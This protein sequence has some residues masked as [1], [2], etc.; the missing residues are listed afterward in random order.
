M[1]T[2]EIIEFAPFR[3]K[4]RERGNIGS[5][6]IIVRLPEEYLAKVTVPFTGEN[7]Y[8]A[9]KKTYEGTI[10]DYLELFN[11]ETDDDGKFLDWLG[12]RLDLGSKNKVCSTGLA[13]ILWDTF[14]IW[15]FGEYESPIHIPPAAYKV[16]LKV[17]N[18]EDA[19]E[20]DYILSIG[21]AEWYEFWLQVAYWRMRVKN[22]HYY[23][24]YPD[25]LQFTHVQQIIKIL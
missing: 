2:F 18:K 10:Y 6:E 21:S 19:R 15:P 1:S 17:I 5:N 14:G 20:G 13:Q 23:P 4:K 3:A 9:F 8:K 7:I 11:I 16:F 24:D 12:D 22:H 25:A